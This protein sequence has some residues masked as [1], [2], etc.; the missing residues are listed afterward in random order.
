MNIEAE[1]KGSDDNFRGCIGG[2]WFVTKGFGSAGRC[3][4]VLTLELPIFNEYLN[5]ADLRN[6]YFS[7]T[8]KISNRVSYSSIST[9]VN[10][11]H[12]L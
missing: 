9:R 5:I 10:A 8:M 6:S 2:C 12:L 3:E 4:F 1:L 11:N 7:V